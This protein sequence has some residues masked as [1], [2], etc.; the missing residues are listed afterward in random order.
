MNA[1]W[2]DLEWPRKQGLAAKNAKNTKKE[3]GMGIRNLNRREQEGGKG[4]DRIYRTNKIGHEEA[5]TSQK[6]GIFDRIECGEEGPQMA[7][8][9]DYTDWKGIFLTGLTG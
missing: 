2:A 3:T 4:F 7:Q 9:T 5:Q 1:D 8:I 6:K